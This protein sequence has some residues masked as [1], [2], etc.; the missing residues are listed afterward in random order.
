M[1]VLQLANEMVMR[2]AH[3]VIGDRCVVVTVIFNNF[4]HVAVGDDVIDIV[5]EGRWR[6]LDYLWI[7]NDDGFV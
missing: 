3:A 2:W 6:R 7:P 5:F 4:R 1:M